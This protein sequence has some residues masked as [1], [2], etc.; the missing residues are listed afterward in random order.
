MKHGLYHV[1]IPS[2]SFGVFKLHND[3]Q[4]TMSGNFDN[5]VWKYTKSFNLYLALDCNKI[6]W[7][8]KLQV[9]NIDISAIKIFSSKNNL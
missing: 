5:L 4:N 3:K 8:M 9:E 6:V 7:G 2:L 1:C